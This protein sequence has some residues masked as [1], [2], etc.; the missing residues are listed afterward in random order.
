[1]DIDNNPDSQ[2]PFRL[3]HEQRK[4]LMPWRCFKHHR[5]AVIG[6]M[7][8]AKYECKVSES[9]TVIDIRTGKDIGTYTRRI[10]AVTFKETNRVKPVEA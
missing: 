4:K 7:I 1:M 5:N 3:W 2:R 8:E 9:I 6:A 10:N